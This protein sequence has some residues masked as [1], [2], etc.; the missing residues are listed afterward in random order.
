MSRRNL[1]PI[2][3]F[4]LVFLMIIGYVPTAFSEESALPDQAKEVV[5]RASGWE[6]YKASFTLEVKEEDGKPFKVQGTLLYKKPA[7][8]RLEVHEGEAQNSTQLLVSDGKTEWQYY[9]QNR[10]VYR[11]TNPPESPA[12]HRPFSEAKLETIRFV[13]RLEGGP[14]VLLR[15]EG[16][17]LPALA[18]L[19]GAPAPVKGI[20]VDVAEKDGLLREMVLLDEK[21]EKILTHRYSQVEVNLPIADDQFIF[22]PPEGVAVMDFPPAETTP[23]ARTETQ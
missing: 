22:T 8:R 16:E 5:A 13:K 9:P 20:R 4:N 6:S 10:V 1:N 7:Y 11:L 21:G 2:A 19:E 23:P 3:V 12:P 14:E 15:F 18:A 17:P